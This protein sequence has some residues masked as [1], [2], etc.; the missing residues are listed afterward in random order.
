MPAHARYLLN[1]TIC[2][3]AL[4]IR[5]SSYHH[6]IN[7]I[8]TKFVCRPSSITNKMITGRKGDRLLNRGIAGHFAINK[9]IAPLYV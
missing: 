9:G 4:R 1:S 2:S 3:S 6:I 8:F 7:I 5:S